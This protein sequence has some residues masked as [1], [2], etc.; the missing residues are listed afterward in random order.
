MQNSTSRPR[1]RPRNVIDHY[2]RAV[3]EGR[4]LAGKYHRLACARHLRDRRRE[5][6]RAFPWVFDFARAQR[7]F[8]F[9]ENLKHY[10][11]EWAGRLIVLERHQKFRLGSIFAWVHRDTGL[12]FRHVYFEIPRKNG[13]S[14]M[15]SRRSTRVLRRRTSAEGVCHRD[16][17]SEQA[18][19]RLQRLQTTSRSSRLR[20]HISI[21]TAN[22]HRDESASSRTTRADRDSTDGLNPHVVI[23]DEAHAMKHRGLIDVMETATGARRQPLIFWITTAGSD[24]RSPCGDQHDYACKVLDEVLLDD[25][26]F[27]FIAHA[28]ED[29]P[30][31]VERT[32]RKANPNYGVSVLPQDIRT[33]ATKARHMPAAAAAFKQK[34]LNL[35]VQVSLPWLSIEGWRR[36]QSKDWRGDDLQDVPC[37]IG[38]D[39]SSKIDLT[40]IVALFPPGDDDRTWRAVVQCLTPEDT[41]EERAHRDRAKYQEW[42]ARGFLRTNPGARIDQDVVREI[43]REFGDRFDVQ[44]IGVDPRNAGNLI[45][46]SIGGRIRRGRSPADDARRCRPCR[47]TSNTTL[48]W[49]GRRCGE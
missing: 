19:H 29:D 46:D 14:S 36:G 23:V 34:R 21:L 1:S 3:V 33:L 41:V 15:P 17:L 20:N 40:A 35:W 49:S 39:M 30:P 44:Q 10:K 45:K 42:I 27:P 38:I 13:K 7:F 22:L 24:A 43:V 4:I 8:R 9:A 26:F 18:P 28:D 32:W 47:R 25:A 37:W 11:G 48:R 2:A 5:G 16:Q 31:F 12:R 6:T